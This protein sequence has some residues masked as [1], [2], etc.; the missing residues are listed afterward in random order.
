V[1][2]VA[3]NYAG[4]GALADQLRQAIV[5]R[6]CGLKTRSRGHSV[7]E[8]LCPEPVLRITK[9]KE[10]GPLEVFDYDELEI[11]RQLTLIEFEHYE[12]IMPSELLGQAWS[13]QKNQHK[14]PNVLSMI[15]HSNDVSLWIATLILEPARVKLR[16]KRFAKLIKVA[17][18]LR[19]LNNFSMLMA[20]LAGFNNSSVSR[21][22]FTKQLLPKRST[23]VLAELE[24][25]MSVEKS[26]QSYR[27]AL[28]NSNPPCIPYLGTYLS[29]LTF[30]DEGNPDML[31]GLI[32]MGKRMLTHRVISEIQRYQLIGYALKHVPTVSK[33]IKD[34][35]SRDEKV[36]GPQLY[37][38]SMSREPRGAEK[39]L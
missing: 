4:H 2:T 16:A 25:V 11:A 17:E 20:F 14:A 23:D 22:R 26:S 5:K 21:L 28:H 30:I 12:K 36:F 33:F 19:T 3:A 27:A 35:P 7:L 31:N 29:D 34:I 1:D 39:V 18:Q 8:K 13:K 38:I 37:D 6:T 32:N 15:A 9:K 24:A 10:G